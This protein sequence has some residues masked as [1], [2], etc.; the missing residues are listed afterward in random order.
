MNIEYKTLLD[1]ST[2]CCKPF[3]QDRIGFLLHFTSCLKVTSDSLNST[4]INTQICG[5]L[6]YRQVKTQCLPDD[7][8]VQIL[9]VSTT[10]CRFTGC[11]S[12]CIH[13][14]RLARPAR[15]AYMHVMLVAK[16]HA[17]NVHEDRILKDYIKPLYLGFGKSFLKNIA[18]F[19]PRGSVQKSTL[20]H[21]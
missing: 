13:T 11:H 14:L 7:S 17:C 8:L 1:H 10:P 20:P 3:L 15:A 19:I 2:S 6:L 9:T 16:V 18:E 12:I 4:L 5:N 21:T